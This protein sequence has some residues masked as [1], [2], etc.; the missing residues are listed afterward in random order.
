MDKGA[1]TLLAPLLSCSYFSTA[2]P[3]LH[4]RLIHKEIV[5]VDRLSRSHDADLRIDADAAF[6]CS[7][8]DVVAVEAICQLNVVE[9]V[10]CSSTRFR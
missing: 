2:T 9:H 3:L 5:R 4:L 6:F 8:A 7:L 10:I 1:S